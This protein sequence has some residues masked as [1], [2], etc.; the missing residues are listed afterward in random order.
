MAPDKLTYLYVF[1][2][3][4]IN[5]E[6]SI[7]APVHNNIVLPVLKEIV[8]LIN[9]QV[10]DCAH[11]YIRDGIDW[12]TYHG[13]F[14]ACNFEHNTQHAPSMTLYRQPELKKNP[15]TGDTMQPEAKQFPNSQINPGIFKK[16]IKDFIPDYSIKITS[17]KQFDTFVNSESD[18]DINKVLLFTK[19]DKLTPAFMSAIAEVRDRVRFYVITIAENDPNAENVEL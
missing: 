10:Y 9:A 15:Y 4:H 1:D 5:K 6:D 14:F 11:P 7:V 19:K 8:G 17:R 12:E 2:S 18:K 3:D 13:P 16:W